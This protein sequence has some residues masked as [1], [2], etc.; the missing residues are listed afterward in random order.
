MRA[1]PDFYFD[2]ISQV[3]VPTGGPGRVA[4]L[5]DAGYCGSP[6]TGLGTSMSLVG[7]RRPRG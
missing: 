6:L 2:A 4:L 5:G 3:H 7:A 1:P